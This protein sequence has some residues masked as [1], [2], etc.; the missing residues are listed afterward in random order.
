[1]V[2]NE[3]VDALC[4]EVA[5]VTSE[6]RLP[7][8]NGEPRAP[9]VVD[10]YLPPKRSGVEDDFPFVVVRA[11]SGFS[12]M[13]MTTV[14]VA[15]I[16]GCY[17]KEYSGYKFCVNVATRIRDALVSLENGILANRY[18]LQYPLTWKAPEDLAYPFWQIDMVTKWAFNTPQILFNTNN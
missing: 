6:Y 12:D 13:E 1:M 14:T 2:E 3:L 17:S 7:V 8:E 11:E 5:K 15:I 10:G 18:V 9:I 4:A 16:V